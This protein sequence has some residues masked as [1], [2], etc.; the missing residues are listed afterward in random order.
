[1]VCPR[2][3]FPL[4]LVDDVIWQS[5]S[6]SKLVN[7]MGEWM[8]TRNWGIEVVLEIV[9]VHVAIAETASWGNVEVSNDLVH[10]ESSL[11]SAAFFS[12]RIEPLSIVFPLTLL[13]T[14]SLAKCP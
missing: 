10:A 6:K 14:L 13:D 12:L 8:S 2:H 7:S 11:N 4:E 1:M 3:D 9:N 5:W